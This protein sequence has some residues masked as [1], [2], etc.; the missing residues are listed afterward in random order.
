MSFHEKMWLHNCPSLFKPLL[1]QCYVDDCFLLFKPLNHVP[2]F[3]T[4]LMANILTSLLHPNWKKTVSFLFSMLKYFA[5]AVNFPPLFIVNLLP[6][7]FSRISTALIP[8]AY[9]CSLVSCLL[10][11]IFNLCST[12][13]NFHAQLEVVPKKI[14]YFCL[15]SLG[16]T[17]F[18]VAIK[19][20]NAMLLIHILTFELFFAPQRVS[21]LPFL[22]RVKFPSL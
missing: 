10:H 5:Q 9:K 19:S 4:I 15:S 8:L 3:L 1:Y 18:K 20:L 22:L 21:L 6:L 7:V 2:L 11:R 12:Y 17:L 13:E 14:V 16:H